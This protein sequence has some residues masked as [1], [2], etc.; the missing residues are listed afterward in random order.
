M[1]ISS[2]SPA[3]LAQDSRLGSVCCTWEFLL[4]LLRWGLKNLYIRTSDPTS[5][6]GVLGFHVCAIASSF[7]CG[8]GDWS[9]SFC[10]L[11]RHCQQSYTHSLQL[12]LHSHCSLTKEG[13]MCRENTG[14]NP[15]EMSSRLQLVRKLRRPSPV[16]FIIWAKTLRHLP[17]G[18]MIQGE[19]HPNLT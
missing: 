5:L 3:V 14:P 12:Y 9:Q 16:T 6:S 4:L 10:V 7:L 11:G 2:S 1:Q 19:P 18:A 17:S 13:W 15:A 8:G